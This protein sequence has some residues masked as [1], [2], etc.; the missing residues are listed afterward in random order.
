MKPKIYYVYAYI[1]AKDSENGESGSPYYIG[2]GKGNRAFQRRRKFPY[3]ENPEQLVFIAKNLFEHDAFQI[4]VLFIYLHG[5]IDLGT[6]CLQNRTDGGEGASGQIKS[7]A[8]RKAI[9]DRQRGVKKSPES[10]EKMRAKLKGLKQSE[11]TKAKRANTQRGQKRSEEF[12]S[13]Q[14]AY[15]VPEERKARISAALKGRTHSPERIENIKKGIALANVA[16][17]PE[18]R[19]SMSEAQYRRHGVDPVA[20]DF[21][22]V[23]PRSR[24]PRCPRA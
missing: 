5:R 23:P 24:N 16:I 4:E 18:W 20:K 21:H 1:R 3:P 19:K 9:S 14:R 13:K 7:D 22:N 10:V 8:E 17:T 12:K 2:K 15:K 6:G 11:H